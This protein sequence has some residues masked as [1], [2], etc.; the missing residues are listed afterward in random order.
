MGSGGGGRNGCG[1][2]VGGAER[3]RGIEIGGKEQGEKVCGYKE[4]K[5]EQTGGERFRLMG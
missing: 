5:V 4:E 2:S 1:G 3:A